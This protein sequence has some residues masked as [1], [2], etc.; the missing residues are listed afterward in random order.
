MA[1]NTLCTEL[2]VSSCRASGIC[3]VDNIQ[4]CSKYAACSNH[5]EPVKNLLDRQ[6]EH[7]SF[8]ADATDGGSSCK[9]VSLTHCGCQRT[10]NENKLMQNVSYHQCLWQSAL[11]VPMVTHN[12]INNSK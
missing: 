10:I 3:G 8:T 5:D 7:N 9:W 12:A 11:E 1:M 4:V 2:H 6:E